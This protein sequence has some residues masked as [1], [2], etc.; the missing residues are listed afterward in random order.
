M[1]K[2][3]CVASLVSV[4]NFSPAIAQPLI[5]PF[6]DYF[7]INSL[8]QVMI[9]SL[10]SD[11]NVI[12]NKIDPYKFI[13]SCKSTTST[14][15]GNVYVTVKLDDSNLCTLHIVD[16]PYEMNPNIIFVNC[17]GRLKFSGMDH[18]WGTYQYTL[19]FFD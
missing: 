7:T 14:S 17:V 4:F 19:K 6:N 5:C 1:K 15:S 9:S 13:A 16:G 18:V 10:S 2:L 3:I 11:G 12:A 8:D